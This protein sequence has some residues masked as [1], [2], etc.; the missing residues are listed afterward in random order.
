MIR[1]AAI[2]APVRTPIGAFGGQFRDVEA[3]ALAAGVIRALIDRTGLDPLLVD[4]VVLGQANPTG[5]APAIGRW[6]ALEA[7]LPERVPGMQVDRRCGSGLMAVTT[8]A[9]MVTSGAADV[10]IAG[11]VESMS[12]SEYYSLD[13]RWGRKAGDGVLHDRLDRAR[14]R[15]QPDSR[16]GAISGMIETAEALAQE[17]AISREDADRY[18]A[19]SHRRAARARDAGTFASEIVPVSVTTRRGTDLLAQ[20]EGIRDHTTAESLAGLRP[21]RAG[22]TVT[23]GNACQQNDAASVCLVVAEDQLDRLELEPAG[24][25]VDW[26]VVGCDPRR[27]GMGPVPAVRELFRRT[28]LTFDDM[29]LVE[30]NEAFACQVLAVLKGWDWD[31]RSKLNVNGSG[32]SLGHPVG[33]T[34]ARIMTTMLH[35]LQRRG[36]SFGVETMC[37]GGGQGLA[38]VFEAAI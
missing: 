7:G 15:A 25:L 21:I 8:A 19:E 32:I 10:V 5:E 33:A 3:G 9:M 27:M 35:E 37:I 4:D 6:A 12:Q 28:G 13:A 11:G 34:G 23:A 14:V 26:C 24:F 2:V 38:A 20:D 22:G 30:V 16:Y 36:A 1:R 29:D 17:Y 18:A 31:D